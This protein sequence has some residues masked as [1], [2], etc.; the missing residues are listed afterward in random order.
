M[1]ITII[2]AYSDNRVIG[3]KNTLP[4]RISS[5]LKSFKEHTV[6]NTVIMGRKTWDSLPIKPLPNRENIVITRNNIL[7][8]GAV[9][10]KSP[11]EAISLCK[12]NKKIFII[13]GS[14]IYEQFLPISSRILAT[15]IHSLLEGD[16]FFPKIQSEIWLEIDRK[17]QF[18]ENNYNYDFVTYIKKPKNLMRL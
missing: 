17:P 7:T 18:S 14:S 9:L 15:E 6:N 13:G 16:S 8:N 4:W 1:E 11:S 5:D 2:V 10:A 3:N 12:P